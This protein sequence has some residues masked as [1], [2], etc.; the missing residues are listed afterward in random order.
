MF[1]YAEAR[2]KCLNLPLWLFNLASI[3]LVGTPV[4]IALEL[5]AARISLDLATFFLGL[6][7]IAFLLV[8]GTL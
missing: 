6:L 7:V 3:I 5:A 8:R 1:C 4:S 2:D